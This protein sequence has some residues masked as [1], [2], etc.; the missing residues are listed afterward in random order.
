M[1][2]IRKLIEW[3]EK[4]IAAMHSEGKQGFL[5]EE[6]QK[7]VAAARA[8]WTELDKIAKVA[9]KSAACQS[10]EYDQLAEA[11]RDGL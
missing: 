10:C 2:A 7:T 3:N 9:S 6:Y 11:I 5:S 1:K 4:S 8:E